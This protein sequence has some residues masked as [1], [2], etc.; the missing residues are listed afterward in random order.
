MS[1]SLSIVPFKI[2]KEVKG[3]RGHRVV[4]IFFYCCYTSNKTAVYL[5]IQIKRY[6]VISHN[7]AKATSCGEGSLIFTQ[8]R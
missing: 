4:F 5:I 8:S 2:P 6:V 3:F 1:W 7:D